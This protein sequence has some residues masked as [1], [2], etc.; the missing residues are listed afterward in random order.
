MQEEENVIDDLG[1]EKRTRKNPFGEEE[2]EEEIPEQIPVLHPPLEIH[3]LALDK[4]D[5]HHLYWQV[6]NERYIFVLL[7][8]QTKEEKILKTLL[9][10]QLT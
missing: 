1:G 3:D 2:K 8:P 5:T 9:R 4:N 10:I 7:D 6:S